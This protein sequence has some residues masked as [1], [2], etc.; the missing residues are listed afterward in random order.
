M[1]AT[2]HHRWKYSSITAEE[3]DVVGNADEDMVK[4]KE[5][6][7][8]TLLRDFLQDALLIEGLSR[9]DQFSMECV[10]KFWN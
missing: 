1:E 6:I 5:E 2:M 10:G 8:Y 7:G 4:G 9:D 3:K